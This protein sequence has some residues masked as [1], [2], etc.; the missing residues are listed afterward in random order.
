VRH[1]RSDTDPQLKGTDL[2]SLRDITEN[3]DTRITIS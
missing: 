3:F 2:R 1:A